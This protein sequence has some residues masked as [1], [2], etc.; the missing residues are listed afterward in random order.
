MDPV[1]LIK[2]DHRT[3]K[4][5]FRAFGKATKRTERQRIGQEI[6]GE[7]SLH[8]AM[9]EQLIYP[10]LRSRDPRS[11]EAVLRALE[12][13]HA[14]KLILAELD[15]LKADDE[16]YAAKMHFVQEAVEMHMDEEELHLLPKLDRL[17][18]AEEQKTMLE[19]MMK[20]KQTA[21]RHPHP[22]FPDTPPANMVAA[23]IARITDG[24]RDLLHKVMNGNGK[25]HTNGTARRA[26]RKVKAAAV[27]GAKRTRR[28]ASSRSATAH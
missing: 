16:R 2:Q 22:A 23:M 11:N 24:G 17:L 13:H 10:A 6:I 27:A 3:I 12:E 20:L 28:A 9:E 7:L 4:A 18:K 25:H 21:P 26:S 15:R 8:T 14:A 19:A 5:L 1:K